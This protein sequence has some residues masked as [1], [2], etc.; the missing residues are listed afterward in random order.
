MTPTTSDLAALWATHRAQVFPRGR[1]EDE[2]GGHD[3]MDLVELDTFL[4]GYSSRVASGSKLSIGEASR[5]N[6]MTRELR[7]ATDSLKGSVAVYFQSLLAVA[8]ATIAS[9]GSS[10]A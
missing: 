1:A 3:L 9:T 6:D 7:Q 5:M 2:Y 4:A 8:E 10:S